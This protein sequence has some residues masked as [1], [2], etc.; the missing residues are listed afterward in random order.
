[1]RTNS[2]DNYLRSLDYETLSKISFNNAEYT[3][4]GKY[5][6][7]TMNLLD[8]NSKR[9]RV[10]RKKRDNLDEVIRYETIVNDNDSILRLTSMSKVNQ[11]KFFK[12]YTDSLKSL[13]KDKLKKQKARFAK[14]LQNSG[15]L[16]AKSFIQGKKENEGFYFYNTNIVENGRLQFENIYGKRQLVDNW[17]I[18]SLSG[19]NN[20]VEAIEVI[21]EGYDIDKDP[22][23]VPELYVAKIPTE[24]KVID[25]LNGGLNDAHFQLGTL[26]KEQLREYFKASESFEAVLKNNPDEKYILPSKY[27]LYKIY[28]VNGNFSKEDRVRKDILKNH[29]DSR[30]A[31]IVKDPFKQVEGDENS[32][33]KDYGKVYKKYQNQDY[34]TVVRELEAMINKYKGDDL[35]LR[36]VLLKAKALGKIEGVKGMK[37]GL[38][39]LANTFPQSEEGKRAI[40]LLSKTIP[41]LENMKFQND[42]SA[43]ARFKLVYDVTGKDEA[44]SLKKQLDE[45]IKARRFD[46]LKTTIDFYAPETPLVVVHGMKGKDQ[47]RAVNAL[48]SDDSVEGSLT[49][50]GIFV[51]SDNYRVIQS[52]KKLSVYKNQIDSLF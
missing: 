30:F 10:I 44:V 33:D 47:V 24:Q 27:N 18:S 12:E 11:Q 8:N 6:D 45:L 36:L 23:F 50:K 40:A 48:L 21:D 42:T 51:S 5:M 15:N 13:A 17:K 34:T 20:I 39:Y 28:Q 43:K 9:Y 49:R 32:F 25:S 3:E 1:M 38:E 19:L 31:A 29:P 46:Q 2:S 26:Y 4:A 16:N 7:S 41:Y 14:R 37:P 52:Q 35:E 22:R